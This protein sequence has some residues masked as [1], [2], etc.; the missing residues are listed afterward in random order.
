M[1]VL[2]SA[3]MFFFLA[4]V[5]QKNRNLPRHLPRQ[6]P[7]AEA[8]Y[9]GCCTAMPCLS[10]FAIKLSRNDA[11]KTV[12]DLSVGLIVIRKTSVKSQE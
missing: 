7:S 11:S 4:E 6:L 2:A 3:I 9:E 1:H 12:C 10:R 8:N 5:N